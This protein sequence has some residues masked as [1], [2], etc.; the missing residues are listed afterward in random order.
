MVPSVTLT[1]D[2]PFHRRTCYHDTA[3]ITVVFDSACF[4]VSELDC[5]AC[6][7]QAIG[8]L[9]RK[10]K[11]HAANEKAVGQDEKQTL[12]L[13][14][15]AQIYCILGHLNLLLENYPKGIPVTMR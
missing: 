9:E 7:M 11:Q 14:V 8:S 5:V 6:C 12:S 3:Q 13:P 10:L 15:D 2:I 1:Y 4:S